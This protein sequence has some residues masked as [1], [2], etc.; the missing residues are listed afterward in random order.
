MPST[1]RLL[2]RLAAAAAM[3]WAALWLLA[4]LVD[5]MPHEIVVNVPLQQP[6]PNP[7]PQRTARTT[8]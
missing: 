4:T 5:P 3:V 7:P 2:G 1:I 6:A 8:P